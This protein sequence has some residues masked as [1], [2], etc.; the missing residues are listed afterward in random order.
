MTL[1]LNLACLGDHPQNVNCWDCCLLSLFVLFRF[2]TRLC[3]NGFKLEQ[4]SL[5]P[6]LR[7]VEDVEDLRFR[8][9][10][11]VPTLEIETEQASASIELLNCLTLTRILRENTRV[12]DFTCSHLTKKLLMRKFFFHNKS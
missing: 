1:G 10:G 3:F 11:V 4:F 6:G 12:K 8:L 7:D 2:E 9:G 5:D